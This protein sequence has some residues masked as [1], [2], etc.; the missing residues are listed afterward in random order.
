M[1][2]VPPSWLISGLKKSHLVLGQTIAGVTQEQAQQLREEP[3]GWT[4]LEI[5]CHVRDHQEIYFDRVK[6][7]VAE[8]TPTLATFDRIAMVTERNYAGQN[9]REVFDNFVQT[10]QAFIE[11]VSTLDDA[12]WDRGGQHPLTGDVTVKTPTLHTVLHDIDHA[13][14]IGRILTDAGL[15]P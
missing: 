5:I 12:Q 6:R 3:D 9:L 10:R 11:F 13:E 2:P 7:M 1:T 8:D 4:I 14:Q 15:R